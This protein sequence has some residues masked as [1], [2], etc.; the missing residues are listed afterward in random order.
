VL[1]ALRG[2]EVAAGS[3]GISPARS[4]LIAFALSAFIAG[5]GGAM[6]AMLQGNVNYAS[7]F[8][9]YGA[10]F[11]IVIVVTLSVR[12]V[13]GAIQAAAAFSLFDA[14]VLKGA[15][16]GWIL[17]EPSRIPG[18]LPISGKWLF[19]LFGFGAIQYARHPEGILEYNKRKRMVKKIEK[20]EREALVLA[21]AETSTMTEEPAA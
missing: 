9:P 1:V 2:S 19:V 14:V 7:N 18:F 4:R 10:L 16:F 3:I 5:I 8:S 13:E 21:G 12:T 20:R 11:W 15:I 17:R 6:L